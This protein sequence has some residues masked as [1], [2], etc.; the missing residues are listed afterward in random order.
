[1]IHW[2]VKTLVHDLL[3]KRRRKA[4]LQEMNNPRAL[5]VPSPFFFGFGASSDPQYISK[6]LKK[7]AEI[8]LWVHDAAVSAYVSASLLIELII[9]IDLHNHFCS[10]SLEAV[11]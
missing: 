4:I 8:I 6:V 1:M 3:K 11:Y 9:L 7:G 5:L 10:H 2:V